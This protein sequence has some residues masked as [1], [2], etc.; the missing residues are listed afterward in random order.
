MP[1]TF[2]YINDAKLDSFGDVWAVG[3][4]LTKYDG[5][6]WDY[7]DSSNSVVPSNTP[8][9]LDTRS[10]SIDSNDNKWVGCAVT[11]SLSQDLIFVAN[12]E[13]AATGESWSLSQFG[14]L[15]SI[16][17]NWDVPTIYASPY[18][19]EILAFISPLNGG[20]GT[21]GTANTGVTGGYLWRY[22][23]VVEEW[24]EVSPGYTWPHIY[25]ITAKGEG[26]NFFEYYLSTND[27]LQI[28]PSGKLDNA[29][30]NDGNLYIPQLRRLNSYTSGIGGNIVYSTSFDENGNYWTGTENGITY[31]DGKKFY[32]WDYGSGAGVTKVVA[33]KNGHVFFRI[34]DP[35][36][37]TSTSVGFYHFNGDTFTQFTTSNS[38]LPD[39]RV[40]ALLKVDEKS[41]AGSLTAFENDLWI[42][43]GN[44]ISLFDYIIPHVYGT[45]KYTGTTGWNFVDYSYTTEGGTADTARIPKA[46]KYSWVYPSWRPYDNKYLENLHPGLDPRNLFLDADF[47][48]IANG[49]AGTQDYWNKGEIVPIED[50]D[51][52]KLIPNSEWLTDTTSFQVTSVSRYKNLNVV[53]G[54]SSEATINLGELNNNNA[55]YSLTNPNPTNSAG[56]TAN[57]GFVSFYTD[58][59]QIRTSIP[60]RGFE[61]KVYKALPSSDDS[62]LFVLGTFKK[63]IEFSE[64]VFSSTY[65]G[66]SLMNVTGV[67]GP[68][69]GPIGFSNIATPGLTASSEYPWI[70]N[71]PTGATSGIFLPE[72]GFLE[73]KEAI[74]I[75]EIDVDLGNKVSYG[76]IDFSQ[77]GS[78]QSQFCL[79]N[80]RYFPGASG[81]Y[82]PTG[83]IDANFSAPAS[84]E[85]LDLAVSKNSVRL[86]SNYIGGISTLKSGWT[87][88]SDFPN[89]PEFVFSAKQSA[90]GSYDCSGSVIDLNSNLALRDAFTVG[91]SGGGTSFLSGIS[92]L[93]NG[94]TYLLTGT[95]TYDVTSNQIDLNHPDPGYS[96]PFFIL[97]DVSNTGITG[98]FIANKGGATAAQFSTWYNTVKGFKSQDQYYLNVLYS[99][100]GA[101]YSNI[102]QD[103]YGETGSVNLMT[104]SIGPGGASSISSIYEFLDENYGSPYLVTLSDQSDLVENGDQYTSIYYTYTPGLTGSGNVI[105][106]RNVSGTYVDEFSTFSQGQTGDQSQLKFHVNRNLNVFV[107]GSSTGIT[108]PDN[109]P[110][111]AATGSFVS[112]LESYK[113]GTGID[114]GNIIS[115][116]GSSAWSWVDVHNS[117][118]DI[119]V[120]LLSTIFLSNYDSKIFGKKNNRWV[121]TNSITNEVLLDVKDVEYF[122]YTFTASGYYSIQNSVED[123]AGNVYEVSKPAFVKVV[124]QTIPRQDDPNPEFVNSR[125]YGYIQPLAGFDSQYDNLGK[126]LSE[127][128]K[129][130]MLENMVPFGSALIIT[131]NPDATFNPITPI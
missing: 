55:S 9:Y 4:D 56:G 111:A 11:A 33:R 98:A 105:L 43:S 93:E 18:T 126:D 79:K 83:V 108:G 97:N 70:L 10:I 95:S 128:Q 22:D 96:F 122:I 115:R 25:E 15:S 131:D 101:V 104:L 69:G 78:P 76:D 41:V 52:Q 80:F 58:G 73:D 29:E 54:Y 130:I 87:G 112:L 19:E 121:L 35:F 85:D 45:S 116:A 59:G 67:T 82:D 53:T 26:G 125:D 72:T 20:A 31:W 94:S 75:A 14:N 49:R 39:D 12:G 109:L 36:L 117:D 103:F 60:F 17:P 8:Y 119:F 92:S 6:S 120:P 24:S 86:I 34:G 99:G 118:S 71:G 7:F 51:I 100:N 62:S 127:Q 27:G 88:Q 42:V 47:K 110:Y 13:Q 63:F 28:I 123:C 48:A 81:D 57:V 65:P 102:I 40:I 129:Q 124:D 46:D 64:L 50:R 107:S 114:L 106:K 61:T 1:T 37:L 66:A 113:P 32:T 38:T 90:T 2:L 74:F 5:T 91:L 68:T 3:R 30:L 77:V 84:I 23:K 44:Y 89:S 21:G 16:S